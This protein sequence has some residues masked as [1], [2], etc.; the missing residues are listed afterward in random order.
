MAE[1]GNRA[2]KSGKIEK[3]YRWENPVSDNSGAITLMRKYQLQGTECVETRVRISNKRK[4]LMDKIDDY[5][6]DAEGK[7]G[8][9]RGTDN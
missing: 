6:L 1:A 3:E 5:C 2:Y 7:W 8:P 9:A 4:Q